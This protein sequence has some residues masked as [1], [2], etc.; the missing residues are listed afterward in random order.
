MKTKEQEEKED[1]ALEQ[2]K[3]MDVSDSAPVPSRWKWMATLAMQ[4]LVRR[5]EKLEEKER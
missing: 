4:A 2:V 5:V 3:N 1:W